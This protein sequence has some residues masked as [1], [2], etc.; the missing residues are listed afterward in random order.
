MECSKVK[1]KD[2]KLWSSLA[3]RNLQ[4]LLKGY[5]VGADLKKI[6]FQILYFLIP[7][8]LKLICLGKCLFPTFPFTDGPSAPTWQRKGIPLTHIT[9]LH[10]YEVS[11]PP[12]NR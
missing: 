3:V 9:M 4:R 5:T 1:C 8:F 7:T 6:S 12:E 11:D 2:L 10:C